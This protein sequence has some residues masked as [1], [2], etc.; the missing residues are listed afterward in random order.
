VR[1]RGT[2]GLTWAQVE[3]GLKAG[4]RFVVFEYCIS[5]VVVTLRRPTDVY[6]LR[7]GQ[8]G[9]VRG[10]PYTLLSLLLGWWGVPWGFIYTPLAVFT[11]LS[12][13]C[14]VT[15]AV[16]ARLNEAGPQPSSCSFDRIWESIRP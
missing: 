12:G 14:D 9:F 3:E 2:R 15:A 16:L 6:F 4:G 11:N 5:F 7:P 13:G 8:W 10:L 1:V